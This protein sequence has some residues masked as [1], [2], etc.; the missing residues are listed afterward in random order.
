MYRHSYCHIILYA[1]RKWQSD[2]LKVIHDTF[3]KCEYF[4]AIENIMQHVLMG[5]DTGDVWREK[6]KL[7][8]SEYNKPNLLYKHG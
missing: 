4:A 7:I 3:V 6:R 8:W 2:I 5:K 1:Q